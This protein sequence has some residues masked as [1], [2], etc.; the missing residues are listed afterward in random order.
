MVF[1]GSSIVFPGLFLFHPR[2]QRHWALPAFSWSPRRWGLRF[3]KISCR[4][5]T[6]ASPKPCEPNNLGDQSRKGRYHM[7]RWMVAKSCTSMVYPI[8]YK[9]STILLVVL[10]VQDFTTIRSITMTMWFGNPEDVLSLRSLKAR[11]VY[12]SSLL[13]SMLGYN[14][15]KK[16]TGT[17]TKT[18]QPGIH[19]LISDWFHRQFW[20]FFYISIISS[21]LPVYIS[22]R[23]SH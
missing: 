13:V 5:C 8:V 21:W 1:L 11:P 2:R 6:L 10:V 14:K 3:C 19:C 7:I 9:V 22:R 12:W 18:N 20:I 4:C 16:K 17:P 15:F 23:L